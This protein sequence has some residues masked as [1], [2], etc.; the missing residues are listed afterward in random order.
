MHRLC[1]AA[2]VFAA[3]TLALTQAGA[4]DK[5]IERENIR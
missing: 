4:A 1:F 3:S 2:A 5:Q